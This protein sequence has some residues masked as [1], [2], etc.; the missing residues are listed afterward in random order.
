MNFDVP[1]DQPWYVMPS[2]G[3]PNVIENPDGF[4][5]LHFPFI[6][7]VTFQFDVH[8]FRTPMSPVSQAE[9]HGKKA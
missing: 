3:F 4:K 1:I 2:V 6:H 8:G 5:S 9:Y 7:G